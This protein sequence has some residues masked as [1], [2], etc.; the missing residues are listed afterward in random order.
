[1][2]CHIDFSMKIK[3]AIVGYGNVG[4]SVEKC[5]AETSDFE[6]VGIFSRRAPNTLNSPYGAKFFE[7]KELFGERFQGQIDVA[8]LSVGS[9][10][11]AQELGLK[12][13]AH[14]C[15]VDS[16]DTHAKMKEYVETL[17]TAGK[18]CGT[19]AI[20]GCGWDPGLFSLMRA[21]FASVMPDSIPQTFWGRGVSQG[22]SEAVRKIEGVKYAT[23]YTVPNEEAV[24][25]AREGRTDFATREKHT[26]E[27]YVVLDYEKHFGKPESDITEIEK[28]AFE[29]EVAAQIVNLPNY[30]AE[31][32][33]TVHF[34]NEAEYL[35]NHTRMSHAG[36]VVAVEKHGEVGSRAEFEL[37]LDSNP[38]FTAQVMVAYAR[39]NYLLARSGETG[40]MTVLDVPIKYL[41]R[42]GK[43]G[44]AFV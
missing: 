7:Q 36:R 26:R 40:A 32:D 27:C 30:F 2:F 12:T 11:D 44:I 20:V 5:I 6:L 24:R 38:D 15:I 29:E 28:Q 37:A 34:V 17:N 4:K 25:L 39:A 35:A 13:A 21:L 10:F 16:F 19:L 42:G 22:H 31:Y 18:M 23:Q 9:A 14:F 8:I 33:T 43:S 1:M 41:L 3:A